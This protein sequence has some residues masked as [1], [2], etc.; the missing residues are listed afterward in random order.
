MNQEKIKLILEHVKT[1]SKTLNELIELI[2]YL[3]AGHPPIID[4][5]MMEILNSEKIKLLEYFHRDL[6]SVKDWSIQEITHLFEKFTNDQNI[7]L[8][9][10]AKPLRIVLTGRIVPTGIYELI[11]ALGKEDTLTRISQHLYK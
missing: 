4:S 5:D 8:I 9:D 1:K 6:S 3:L 10:I 11:Y 7:K 2:E